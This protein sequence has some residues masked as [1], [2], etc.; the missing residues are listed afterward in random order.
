MSQRYGV[1]QS[2]FDLSGVSN[3]LQ[4]QR[5]ANAANRQQTEHIII[6]RE[7]FSKHDIPEDSNHDY[8]QRNLKTGNIV[9]FNM[10]KEEKEKTQ[11]VFP[12][13]P[14]FDE[15]AIEN[16]GLDADGI[17]NLKN[18]GKFIQQKTDGTWQITDI[19]DTPKTSY[20]NLTEQEIKDSGLKI[21]T[22][23]IVQIS[24]EGKINVVSGS[25][26]Q[27]IAYYQSGDKE[28]DDNVEK[29]G[30]TVDHYLQKD[31]KTGKLTP[32][33]KKSVARAEARKKDIDSKKPKDKIYTD[34][35]GYKGWEYNPDTD[36]FEPAPFV[37]TQ[38]GQ[39]MEG[40]LE[41]II[42]ELERK[43]E[44]GNYINNSSVHRNLRSKLTNIYGSL[45][46]DY[47]KKIESDVAT[48][49]TANATDEFRI[50]SEYGTNVDKLLD[51]FSLQQDPNTKA[52]T[53]KYQPT[54]ADQI[55]Q[56]TPLTQYT[57]TLTS[58]E[59]YVITPD[60]ATDWRMENIDV[61]LSMIN[62]NTPKYVAKWDD[63]NKEYN[64]IHNPLVVEV[65][66]PSETDKAV[67]KALNDQID[68]SLN[69]LQDV[70]PNIYKQLQGSGGTGQAKTH[71]A[72]ANT[73][74]NNLG[75]SVSTT[76]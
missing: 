76:P 63:K 22:G 14:K 19:I 4:R 69:Q 33:L 5:S 28:F 2:T 60:D 40:R 59:D 18:S 30:L 31:I 29:L 70:A 54:R 52:Y 57:N 49:G 74:L 45:D 53:V 61:P 41:N 47:L 37:K 21:S 9:P 23:D 1:E 43:D 66:A 3:Y 27:N 26:E 11:Q 75:I 17:K 6:G 12:T 36:K 72:V 68:T 44:Q 62:S 55:S 13:D 73:L 16:F 38:G 39:R 48:R 24:S 46:S 10:G 50:G 64:I 56:M 67:L 7:D 35:Y 8:Y 20:R 65:K 71:K 42:L 34:E 32:V 58:L 25:G 51:R 15:I